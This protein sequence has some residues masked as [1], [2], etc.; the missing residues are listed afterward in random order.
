MK[1]QLNEVTRFKKLAGITEA[2]GD[3]TFEKLG[4]ELASQIDNELSKKQPQNEEL[5]TIAGI[6]GLILSGP[7][8][9][10][11]IGK[12][13]KYVFKE[14]GIKKGEEFG[15]WLATNSHH[16]EEKFKA[17]IKSVVGKFVKDSNKKEIISEAVYALVVAGLG[18]YAGIG[19]VKAIK[20]AEI[21][22]ATIDAIKV[23]TKGRDVA[24]F[25]SSIM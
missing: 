1:Q 9:G 11:Y 15:Q 4:K 20:S 19:A 24:A 16:I 13:I 23:A 6:L 21:G 5:F 3:D 22:T 12:A 7:V 18:I 10:L 17:P 2:E 25:V 14:L 8:L